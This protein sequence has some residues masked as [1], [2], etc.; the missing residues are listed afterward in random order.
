MARTEV[1]ASIDSSSEF[2]LKHIAE[3]GPPGGQSRV[4][5]T[6]HP[7]ADIDRAVLSGVEEWG[8]FT[9][10]DALGVRL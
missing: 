4:F 1:A 6:I 3:N 10:A 5:N 7:L 2:H 8:I 9:V